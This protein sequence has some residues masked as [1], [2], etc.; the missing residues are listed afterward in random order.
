MSHANL[1]AGV[2]CK[3]LL[4]VHLLL[5]GCGGGDPQSPRNVLLVTLDTTRADY[6]GAYGNK[7]QT[8]PNLDALADQG[9]RF[10]LAISTAAVTPV[11]HAS[12]L[13]G[14]YNHEHG[15]RVLS[16]PS[17]FR[18][19]PDTATLASVLK[20]S[21][22]H[23]LAV[24]SAFPV[25]ARF[26]FDRGFDVFESFD[27]TFKVKKGEREKHSWPLRKLQRRSDETTDRVLRHLDRVKEPFFFW[28]HYW[29]PHD[30]MILP[31]EDF[32][33][34]DVGQLHGT[35]KNRKIY[36]AEIRYMDSQ[37]G[38]LLDTLV[39]SGLDDRTLVIV[40]S[41][42][43]EGLGNHGWGKHRI[44]YQEQIR[45]P[46]IVRVPG[47]DQV[48]EVPDLVRS[49][50]I[51]PTVLDYLGIDGHGD[52]TGRSLRGL[53]EGR[54]E[55]GRLAL[56]DQINGFDLNADLVA[57]RPLD[58]FLYAAMDQ[59]W[60]LIYRPTNPDASELYNLSR[61][62]KESQN[63]YA[64]RP[65]EAQRLLE[66]LARHEP[67]VITPFLPAGDSEDLA[68]I[69]EAL[70][71]LGYLG[72]SDAAAGLDWAWACPDNLHRLRGNRRQGDCP[73]PLVPAL[74]RPDPGP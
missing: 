72:G 52:V 6:L 66:I 73:T 53:M 7:E 25:S 24:H 45:L 30:R 42:H 33:P 11:S 35:Y 55:P 54:D 57:A 59:E 64:E 63:L 23:T 22:Y 10:D 41:D 71:A 13:T 38:R 32:M 51:F 20:S 49:I 74:P 48:P 67:W 18:L 16:A 62:P 3:S 29:D 60:K 56:A 21:G 36:A 58:D 31:P 4:I 5:T 27:A 34:E 2:T 17:G 47:Q 44:L 37:I 15:L 46:L 39:A 12:I 43:G 61:D 19:P 65:E 40:V 69:R 14:L 68:A 1:A 28:V 26:G 50:D 9:T 8:T 70:T